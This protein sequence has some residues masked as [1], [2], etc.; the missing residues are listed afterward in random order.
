[1]VDWE[2]AFNQVLKLDESIRS[3]SNELARRK[4]WPIRWGI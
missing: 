3:G 4:A 2:I 1:M